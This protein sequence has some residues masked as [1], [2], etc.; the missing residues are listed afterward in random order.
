MLRLAE[1]HRADAQ[2][3]PSRGV[4]ST[5]DLY[6]RLR[7]LQSGAHAESGRRSFGRVSRGRSVSTGALEA[8]LRPGKYTIDLF[9]AVN[10]ENRKTKHAASQFFSSLLGR[11]KLPQWV[12]S[13]R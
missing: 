2:G 12:V 3:A 8:R 6:L 11:A 1:D 4:Q 7:R 5:S 10:D 9:D 13:I